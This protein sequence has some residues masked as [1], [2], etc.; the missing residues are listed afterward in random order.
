MLAELDRDLAAD[1]LYISKRLTPDGAR[2][3]PQMLREAFSEGDDETLANDL[4]RPCVMATFET[5]QRHGR[6]YSK[7]VPVGAERSLAEGEFNRFYIRALCLNVLAFGGDALVV[8]RAKEVRNPRAASE[9]RIGARIDARA[10]LEDLRANVGLET[11]LGVPGG[12]NSG[13][14]V[15]YHD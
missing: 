10:L 14:S 8:S 2:L 15:R 1:A 7:R 12:P 11:A 13:L 3:Y 6:P 9:S 5:S 4:A